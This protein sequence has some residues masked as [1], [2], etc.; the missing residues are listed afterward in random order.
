MTF[1]LIDSPFIK[2]FCGS[3]FCYL[4]E[5]IFIQYNTAYLSFEQKYNILS[6]VY[7]LLDTFRN[8]FIQSLSDCFN[9]PKE[10][11]PLVKISY[12]LLVFTEIYLGKFNTE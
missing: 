6:I 3:R 7:L 11:L 8:I 5:I 1:C 10:I 4:S 12:Y 9:I 2:R